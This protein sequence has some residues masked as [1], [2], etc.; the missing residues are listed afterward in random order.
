[1]AKRPKENVQAVS[2]LSGWL[3]LGKAA[4]LCQTTPAELKNRIN[5]GELRA[6]TIERGGKVR[7]RV[8]RAALIGAGLLGSGAAP[9][10]P[11]ASVDLLA[12]IRDQNSEYIRPV[13]FGHQKWRPPR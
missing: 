4:R 13:I 3:S 2:A 5:S 1:M 10:S 9:S 12:L 8:S 6:F 11:A 7:F